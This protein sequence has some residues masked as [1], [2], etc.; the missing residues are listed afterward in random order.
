MVH[1]LIMLARVLQE[2]NTTVLLFHV[3]FSYLQGCDPSHPSVDVNLSSSVEYIHLAQTIRFLL[4]GEGS[5]ILIY[6]GVMLGLHQNGVTRI[7][8]LVHT[9]CD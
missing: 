9:I 7:G 6:R 4:S 8:V 5:T 3:C 1:V 2:C